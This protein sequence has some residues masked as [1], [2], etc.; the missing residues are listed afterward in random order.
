MKEVKQVPE[1]T[2]VLM[3]VEHR[4]DRSDLPGKAHLQ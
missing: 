2:P 4:G 1:L 3:N